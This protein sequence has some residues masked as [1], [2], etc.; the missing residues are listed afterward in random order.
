MVLCFFLGDACAQGDAQNRVELLGP[1]A[2]FECKYCEGRFLPK[3]SYEF[4]RGA[5]LNQPF[6]GLAGLLFRAMPLRGFLDHASN[7]AMQL[8]ESSLRKASFLG[9]TRESHGPQYMRLHIWTICFLRMSGWPLFGKIISLN[10]QFTLY[11][12]CRI[13][14]HW[15]SPIII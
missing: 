8:S 13:G 9:D 4:G 1:N 14:F 11:R 6:Q 3:S 12:F 10:C 7:V 15:I 2:F 5:I